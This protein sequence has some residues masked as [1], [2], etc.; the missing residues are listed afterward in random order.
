M[1]HLGD[2]RDVGLTRGRQV[3]DKEGIFRTK[4]VEELFR[5]ATVPGERGS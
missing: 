1:P 5:A 3:K 2:K 4:G